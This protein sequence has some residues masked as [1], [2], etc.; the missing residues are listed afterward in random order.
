MEDLNRSQNK[1]PRS[2]SGTPF[3]EDVQ[4]LK[5]L[6]SQFDSDTTPLRAQH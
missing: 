1:G 4:Q 6:L 5:N 2:T 3:K